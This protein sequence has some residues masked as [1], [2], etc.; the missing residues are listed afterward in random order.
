MDDFNKNKIDALFQEGAARYDFTYREDAWA[1]MDE[2]LDDQDKKRK[3]RFLG[4]W[5]FG[6]I[7]VL[8]GIYGLKQF[9]V[10][11]KDLLKNEVV[12]S[13]NIDYLPGE[14]QGNLKQTNP[15]FVAVATE[16]QTPASVNGIETLSSNTTIT[17]LPKKLESVRIENNDLVSSSKNKAGRIAIKADQNIRSTIQNENISET[18]S[19]VIEAVPAI[20]I[21]VPVTNLAQKYPVILPSGTMELLLAKPV[22]YS[23]IVLPEIKFLEP[24][25][26]SDDGKPKLA[27]RFSVGL[28]AGPEFSFVGGTGSAKAGYY[29]GLELGYQLSDHFELITGVGVSRKRYL[30]DGANYNVQPEF[31]T[32]EIAPMEFAGKCTVIE[33]PVAVNYYFK[34]A[35]ENGWFASLGATTYLMSDEWYDF[36]YDPAINRPDLKANWNDKMVNNHLFGIG[37]V[38]FG[39]QQNLGKH[40]SLQISPYAKIPLRGIGTGSVNLFSTGLRVT[41]RFR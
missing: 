10:D 6:G 17:E 34:E 20:E 28:N 27:D 29:L 38:S 22:D 30:G 18:K 25:I 1:T 12:V 9:S 4:W 33:I 7:A 31:W 23:A 2:L 32:D 11:H 37:Q 39:Y 15:Q 14:D 19:R 21:T 26:K 35:N 3:K 24:I 40:T 8:L 16:K 41:A 13:Q 36:F 5:I